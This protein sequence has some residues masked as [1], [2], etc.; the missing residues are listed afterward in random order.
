M[1]EISTLASRI[2]I[3]PATVSDRQKRQL[4]PYIRLRFL[5]HA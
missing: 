3:A 5:K 1:I 2:L 4:L